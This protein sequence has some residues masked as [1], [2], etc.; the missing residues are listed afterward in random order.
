MIPWH[1]IAARIREQMLIIP[2]VI[3]V[4]MAVHDPFFENADNIF[5]PINRE[6]HHVPE[7]GDRAAFRVLFATFGKVR[8]SGIV[9][10]SEGI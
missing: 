10:E 3:A 6:S 4:K 8:M 5:L 2:S 1:G 9:T 7:C